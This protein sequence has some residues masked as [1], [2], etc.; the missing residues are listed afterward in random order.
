MV[1]HSLHRSHPKESN[2]VSDTSSEDTVMQEYPNWTHDSADRNVS[3]YVVAPEDQE[4]AAG[5]SAL[6]AMH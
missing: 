2:S 5:A 3:A 6:G 1:L 4:K